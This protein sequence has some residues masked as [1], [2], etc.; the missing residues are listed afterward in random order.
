[1]L[2]RTSALLPARY[3]IRTLT[4]LAALALIAGV[5]ALVSSNTN[6]AWAQQAADCPVNHLG[7]LGLEEDTKRQAYGSWTTEDCDSRFRQDSDAHTYRFEVSGEGRIRIDLSSDD[8]DSFVYLMTEDGTLITGDD[9]GGAGLGARIERDLE[10]GVYLVEA[11]T[12]GGRGRGS[13]DF[14][15]TVSRVT[16]CAPTPLGSLEPG[17]GLTATGTWDINTCGSRFVASHPAYGYTFN[18]AEGGR[19]LIDLV[20]E[21][22]D[23]VLSLISSTGTVIGAN[24]DG[25]GRRNSRLDT[26]LTPG[27]YAVEAT[28]YL[29]RDLQP[30][31]ADFTLTIR[32]VDEEAERGKF[33]LKIEE[34]FAPD[35]V[36]AGKPFQVD[37]RVGNVG[38]GD[39]A[40]ANARFIIYVIGPRVFDRTP[41]L[42][43]SEDSWQAGASYHTATGLASATS[44]T[45]DEVTPFSLTFNRSGPTWIFVAVIVYDQFDEEIGF[46]GLWRNLTVLSGTPFAPVTVSVDGVNYTVSAVADEDGDVTTSVTSVSDPDAEVDGATRDKAIYAAGVQLDLLEGIFERPAIAELPTTAEPEAFS[47]HSP[48]SNAMQRAIARQY[49]RDLDTSGLDDALA[50]GVVVNPAAVES[51]ILSASDTASARYAAMAASWSALQAR[52]GDRLSFAEAFE[53][54]AQLAYAESVIASAVAAGEVVQAARDSEMGWEDPDVMDMA[55]GLA[56]CGSGLLGSALEAAGIPK[57]ED[58]LTLDAEMRLALPAY[59]M[60]VDGALC[61]AAG[62]DASTMQF[63]SAYSLSRSGEILQMLEPVP[64]LE[65]PPQSHSLRIIAQMDEDGRLE[66]GVELANGERIMPSSRFTSA[67][68]PVDVWLISSDVEVDEEKSI[69]KIRSRRLEDGRIELGYID[70]LGEEVA[71][72]VRYLA[73]DSSTGVWLRSGEIEVPAAPP[74]KERPAEYTQAF[75]LEAIDRYEELGLEATLEYYNTPESVDGQWYVFI[76]DQDDVMLAHAANP[77]LVGLHASEIR[78]PN[79]YPSGELVAATATEDG[80]WSEYTFPNPASGEVETKH[81][82]AVRYDGLTFGSGW[83]EPGPSKTEDAPG[84][85]QAYVQQA[86]NLYETLGLEMTVDYYNTAESVDDAWYIFVLD[87]DDVFLAHADQDIVG[88]HASEVLGPNDFPTGSLVAASATKEGAWSSYVF[89]NPASGEVEVKRSWI[90]RHNGLIFGSGWYEPGPS[91]TED[92]PGYTQAFVGQALE[93]YE[94][95]G[96]EAAVEYYKTRESVDDQWYVFIINE[97]GYTISHYRPEIIGRD[98]SERVD[99]TGYFYGDDIRSAPEEGHWVTYVFLDPAT[100]QERRKHTWSVNRDGLIFSS[101]WYEGGPTKADAPAYTQAYVQRAIDRYENTGLDATVDYYNNPESIVDQWYMFIFD[102][103][104]VTLALGANPDF[105]GTHAEDIKGPNDYPSGAMVAA[106]ADEDGEWVAYNSINPASGELEAKRSW[107]IR[108]DG[109]IFGSGWHEP[110]PSKDDAPAYTQAFV[111]QAI[112]LYDALGLDAAIEYYSTQESVDDQWYIFIIDEDGYTIAHYRPEIIGRDP[113]ERVDVTG[114]F[115]GDDLR[116]APAEG[117]WVNYVFRDP[118]TGEERQKNA[119]AVSYDG[120]IFGSGWHE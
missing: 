14:N 27:T 94:T 48:S 80:S 54:Q 109:L 23:P 106:A 47:V 107:V 45:T 20:S 68:V 57:V 116:S 90:V 30:L 98:P 99:I 42:F 19:V 26:Y 35:Q 36:V 46:H 13:A 59:G 21:N 87:E 105:V 5:A 25:G 38:G 72:D 11:T 113:S 73:T 28:T 66:H 88:L 78:G 114:Y 101:G 70:A 37:Y 40:D 89:T 61:A 120:L 111:Q 112:N 39:L 4:L 53:V 84:Y 95:L 63:L 2:N 1:M 17:D 43:A 41:N 79:N 85:T 56:S 97:D 83:Y 18:L 118:S 12:V 60:A 58:M 7:V 50:A 24:D 82:W 49:T 92:A 71:P 10:T 115:Y 67:D 74:S 110:A 65:R 32:L 33:L 16:G 100:G 52:T 93:L 69:G 108:H 96:L 22:G 9:E 55:A 103:D 76:A 75:V 86:L 29:Q 44:A 117:H 62:V 81:S 31:F 34:T 91:K 15:L 119:W 3:G 102:E 51:I 8:A 6:T 104:D 77:D 64:T